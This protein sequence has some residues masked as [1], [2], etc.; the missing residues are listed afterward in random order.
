MMRAATRTSLIT[1]LSFFALL[2]ENFSAAEDLPS[3]FN[4]YYIFPTNGSTAV[5]SITCRDSRTSWVTSGTYANCCPTTLTTRCPMPTK[6][7]D[8]TV[9]YDN[10][11]GYSCVNGES[12]ATMT[13]Y[14]TSP[15][16]SPSATNIFCWKNWSAYTVYR[17]LPVEV[18]ENLNNIGHTTYNTL[19][20]D[21]PTIT[22]PPK[23][24][25]PNLPSE[26]I[27]KSSQPPSQSPTPPPQQESESNRGVI[28]GATVGAVAG[29]SILGLAYFF[30]RRNQKKNGSSAMLNTA[31]LDNSPSRAEL[32]SLNRGTGETK[33]QGY[34]G[35]APG[36]IHD[37]GNSHPN[38]IHELP[39]TNE[40]SGG[41][42]SPDDGSPV[43]SNVSRRGPA[44]YEMSSHHG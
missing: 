37:G 16:G 10:G 14:E 30:F 41:V 38:I 35:Y 22:P 11:G 33:G 25:R 29:L 12:C 7:E 8:G 26:S 28:A 23:T 19:V 31:E 34:Y 20:Q 44:T 4:G 36:T 2:N 5:E 27:Q 6:C 42:A 40:P 39:T 9:S 3:W 32:E 15:G 24:S 18:T 21:S 13:V 17:N 43:E 1:A